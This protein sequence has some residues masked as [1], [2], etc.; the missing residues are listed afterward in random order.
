MLL[1]AIGRRKLAEASG[2]R[3]LIERFSEGFQL[4]E[5]LLTVCCSSCFSPY[6][7]NPRANNGTDLANTMIDLPGFQSLW[8]SRPVVVDM[9]SCCLLRSCT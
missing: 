4:L 1:D 2:I 6:T 7:A 3:R 8:P 5:Y 9:L